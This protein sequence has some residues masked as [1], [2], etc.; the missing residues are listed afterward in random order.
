MKVRA[1]KEIIDI[2][3]LFDVWRHISHYFVCELVED[4]GNRNLTE[5]EKRAGYTCEWK[6]LEEAMEIF[7]KYEDFHDID[8]ADYGLY[9][10]EYVAIKEYVEYI[11]RTDDG[12]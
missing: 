4:T 7:G 6:S 11:Q 3:E 10:R 9:K 12:N 1:T 2:E 8:I 5:A